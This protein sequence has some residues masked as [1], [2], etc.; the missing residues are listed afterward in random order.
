[1]ANDSAPSIQRDKNWADVF[2]RLAK[3]HEKF[4]QP[5]CAESARKAAAKVRAC[6][7]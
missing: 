1:M 4:A 2:E 5:K 6:S 3:V 7:K